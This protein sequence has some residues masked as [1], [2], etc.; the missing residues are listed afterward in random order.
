M[1]AKERFQ[2]VMHFEDVDRIPL[3]I[4]EGIT[5]QAIR[6]WSMQG[7][8]VGVNVEEYFGFDPRVEVPLKTTPIPSFIP[9]TVEADDEWTTFIDVHGFTVRQSR[10]QAVTPRV[11]YYVA[12]SM[13]TP[14]DWVEMSKRYD[15]HD[16]RRY[17]DYWGDELLAHYQSLQC[18]IGLSLHWGPGRGIK[19]GY[20]FGLDRFL[21]LIAERPDALQPIFEY[22]AEFLIELVRPLVERVKLD[23]VMLTEDG[24]AYKTSTLV[25]P[26]T[27]RRVWFPHVRKVV[28][29]LR[30]NRIDIIGYAT[31]GNVETLIPVLL[32]TGINLFQ[33]L[34]CA[35]GMDVRQLRSKYG[36]RVLLM[37]NISRQ[38]LMDGVQAVEEEF[39]A[40]LPVIDSGGYIPTVDDMILPDISFESYSHCIQLIK[41]HAF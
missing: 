3:W 9:R 13:E 34:E 8:P 17:P 19:N 26:D 2:A 35:A 38:A 15:P 30:S 33:P 24:M 37:G 18:P 4:V 20:M 40:K 39:H 36:K 6:K 11:Y 1:N 27:Y 28:D 5:E 12:G 31:S 29:F 21:D 10:D 41:G 7:L 14:D 25:S 16:I 32:E 22:W 23:Y